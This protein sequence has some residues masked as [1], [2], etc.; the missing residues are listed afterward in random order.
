MKGALMYLLV[1]PVHTNILSFL[2]KEK[3]FVSQ[4]RETVQMYR[5]KIY[6]IFIV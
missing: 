5:G 4:T 1:S 2:E 6:S 3:K